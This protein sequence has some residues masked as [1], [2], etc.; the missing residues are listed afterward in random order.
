[1]VGSCTLLGRWIGI[2][3]E[4]WW[5]EVH[6]LSCWVGRVGS[7]GSIASALVLWNIILLNPVERDL[8]VKT[9]LF[10]ACS[11][12]LVDIWLDC[13]RWDQHDILFVLESGLAE[14]QI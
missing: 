3:I 10:C 11:L 12:A 2:E 1:M 9:I 7:V 5:V 8:A 13:Q 4:T 6:T 14:A